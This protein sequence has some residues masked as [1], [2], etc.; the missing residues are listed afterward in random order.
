M[1]LRNARVEEMKHLLTAKLNQPVGK[2]ACRAQMIYFSQGMKASQG[3]EGRSRGSVDKY[4]IWEVP[5]KRKG[6]ENQWEHPGKWYPGWQPWTPVLP[7]V[8]LP[9]QPLMS[10]LHICSA[11]SSFTPGLPSR[12]ITC[13][14]FKNFPMRLLAGHSNLNPGPWPQGEQLSWSAPHAGASRDLGLPV[15]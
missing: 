1:Y 11:A 5:E 10:S 6:K 13:I 14:I 12:R 3:K 9:D 2:W 8:A 15:L 7:S 4:F